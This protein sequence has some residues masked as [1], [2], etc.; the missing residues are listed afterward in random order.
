MLRAA[1]IYVVRQRMDTGDRGSVTHWLGELRAGDREAA[2]PLWDRYFQRLVVLA[3]GRLHSMHVATDADEEDAA[4]SAFN[5]FCAGVERGRFPQLAD[6]DNLWRLLV[7]ITKRKALD[8]AN[9][10]RRQK[11]GGGRL[12][13]EADLVG[14][15]TTSPR[16]GL[17][18]LVGEEPTPEFAALVAEEYRNRLEALEDETLRQI[19]SWKLEGYTNEEIAARMG[20]AL[21]TVA[22]KLKLIRL[23][24]EQA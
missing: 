12:R 1:S 8:Q 7:T 10:Q 14:G 11:R 22:N 24:W 13:N 4:L 16:M 21:R 23:R 18:Q 6:R 2:Q 20:C 15:S 19:A 9:R 5:S 17:E 3:R